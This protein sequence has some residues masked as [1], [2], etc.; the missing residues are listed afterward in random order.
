[1]NRCLPSRALLAL[2]ASL[3]FPVLSGLS[4]PAAAQESVQREAP[5]DV[6]LGKMTVVTPPVIQIDG[7]EE[8][9]SPGAR[10]RDTR[11]FMVLSASLS[12]QTVP[13]VFR[14]DPVGL[15]HEVWLLSPDEYRRLGG[16]NTGSAQGVQT[17]LELL[18]IIFGARR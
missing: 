13:V 2:A 9:L 11:N 14:R 12:G 18:A 4:L 5:K 17:F 10:I 16:V 3:A 1:M 6:K 7:K 8:R 15:V